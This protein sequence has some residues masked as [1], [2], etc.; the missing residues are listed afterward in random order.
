MVRRIGAFSIGRCIPRVISFT[1]MTHH[2]APAA[3]LPRWAH[4]GRGANAPRPWPAIRAQGAYLYARC[5]R[6]RSF[7]EEGR[8][9]HGGRRRAPRPERAR[10]PRHTESHVGVRR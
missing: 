5:T 2:P 3:R 4:A 9:L 7:G 1:I 8:A 10:E 6:P